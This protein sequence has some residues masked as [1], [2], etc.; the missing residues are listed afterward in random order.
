[1]G[2][3]RKQRP[4]LSRAR[5]RREFRSVGQQFLDRGRPRRLLGGMIDQASGK[6]RRLARMVG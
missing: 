5:A 6:R 4:G 3:L 2:H 1:M